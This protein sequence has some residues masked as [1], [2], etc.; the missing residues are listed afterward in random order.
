MHLIKMV[1]PSCKF[2]KLQMLPELMYARDDER[3]NLV[4]A[5]H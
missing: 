2:Y 3:L 4:F 5:L 1:L